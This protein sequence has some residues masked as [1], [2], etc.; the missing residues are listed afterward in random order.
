LC[1]RLLWSKRP[2]SITKR[3]F[4][5]SILMSLPWTQVFKVRF[6]LFPCVRSLL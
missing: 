4:L 3:C 1:H 2:A 5:I 6:L